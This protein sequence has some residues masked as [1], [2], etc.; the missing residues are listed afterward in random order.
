MSNVVVVGA[1][2]GDEGKGRLVDWLAGS[3]DIVAR[4]NGGHNAGH[5]LVVDGKTYK[6]ALLPSG[7]VRG[8]LGVLGSG[9]VIDPD[10]LFAEIARVEA[11]GIAVSPANLMIAENAPLVLP[12]HRAIDAAQEKLRAQPIGT[13]LRGIGPAYEDLVGRRA[14]RVCDLADPATLADKIDVLLTHHNAWFRGLGLPEFDKNELLQHLAA[15]TP[16]LLPF[17]QSV[18]SHLNDAMAAGSRVLF[19]GAQAVMLDVSWGTYP[20]VTSSHTLPANAALGTGVGVSKLHHVLGVTKA[21]A[22][23]VG[24]GPFVTEDTGALGERLRAQGHEFGVNTGRPRR[25]GWLDAAQLRQAVLVAGINSLAITKLDVLDGFETVQLCVGYQIDGRDVNELPASPAAQARA[26]PR[27][28]TFP[29]WK[30][31]T[32]GIKRIEDLPQEARA[33][34]ARIEAIAGIPASIITTSPEREDTII[35]QDVFAS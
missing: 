7:I 31:P 24:E 18:W 4:Y 9:V 1:Q 28:E 20:Y 23:R 34:L 21:Y 13:T 25:C 2:W 5:T 11:L 6:L 8:K 3:A 30:T 22:T 15:I 35:V 19:E 27:Y 14:V 32:R 10:A 16:R 33:F 29:G 26:T 17:V 12:I